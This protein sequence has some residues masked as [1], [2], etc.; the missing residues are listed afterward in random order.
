MK[1]TII[2]LLCC[3]AAMA[4]QAAKVKE[5]EARNK[6]QHFLAMSIAAMTAAGIPFDVYNLKGQLVRR[7]TTSTQGLS[8]GYYVIN[9]RVVF[10]T[11]KI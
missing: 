11:G 8:A 7:Q 5:S 4:V 6:A 1:K 10:I 3:F 2:L 9:Q